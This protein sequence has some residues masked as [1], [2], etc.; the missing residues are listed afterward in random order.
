VRSVLSF[1]AAAAAVYGGFV[2][3]VYLYQ[4]RLLYLP[5]V[6]GKGLMAT[7]A[8]IGLEFE[9]REIRTADGVTLHAWFMPAAGARRVVL[10]CHG[11]AGNISHR[12]DSIRIFH[13]LGLA[14]LI[15]DYRGY[16]LSSGHPDEAGTYRDVE[17]VWH[18]LTAERRYAPGEIVLFGR[19]MGA[20]I[21][22]HLARKV[23]AGG[24]ILESAF[25]SAPD[26]AGRYYWYLPVR[27]LARFHYATADYVDDIRSP[28]LIV[29]SP[30]DEIVPFEHAREI[31][32]R[33]RE[34][35]TL[36]EILGDH[37]QGFLLSGPRYTEGL[38]R[39]IG[40]LPGGEGATT[41][42]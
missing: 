26:L 19:S 3:L 10:F 5:D 23:E 31:Y 37:N 30:Q 20:A 6:A 28:L 22:A 2:L 18:Y 11:N 8:A 21:A 24:V 34:P 4:A 16:G 32:R 13:Q 40:S 14:V 35:K 41:R 25:T 12:L 9:E 36:L 42:R 15:F 39:F 27:W 1:L 7:P 29:H 17:A 38:G 33:A